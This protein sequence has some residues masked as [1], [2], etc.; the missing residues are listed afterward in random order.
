MIVERSHKSHERIPGKVLRTHPWTLVLVHLVDCVQS[1]RLILVIIDLFNTERTGGI[2]GIAGEISEISISKWFSRINKFQL[3]FLLFETRSSSQLWKPEPKVS[4][5]YRRQLPP[6]VSI[7]F[8]LV[9]HT[10][11]TEERSKGA[12]RRGTCRLYSIVSV[13]GR[14][15]A[16]SSHEYSRVARNEARYD[17]RSSAVKKPVPGGT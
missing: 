5:R 15:F 7:N 8:R 10:T 9:I 13:H 4:L 1:T 11:N 17:R 3:W 2:L 6:R 12:R 14:N 16:V